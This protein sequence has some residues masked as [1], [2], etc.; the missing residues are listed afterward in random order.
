MVSDP[1]QP[2]AQDAARARAGRRRRPGRPDRAVALGRRDRQHHPERLPAVRRAVGVRPQGRRP[3]RGRG[4]GRAELPARRPGRRRQRRPARRVRARRPGQHLDPGRSSSAIELEGVVDPR[5][6]SKLIKQLEADGLAFEG[7]EASASSCSSAATPPTTP[8]RSGSSTTPASS[9]SATAASC[10]PRRPSRSRSTARSSTPPPTATARSTPSTRPCA[11][12]SA[13]STRASTTSTSSTTRCAS[14]TAAR[15]PRPGPGSIID[16]TDGARTWSTMGS[17]TNIIAASAAALADSLEYAIWKAG[18]ELR[19]RDERHF[20]TDGAGADATGRRRPAARPRPHGGDRDDRRPCADPT[21]HLARWTVTSGSN[22][23]AAAPSSSRSGDHEWRASAEGNGAIDALFRAVDKALA[24]V[25]TGHPRLLAYDIHALGEG[26]DTIGAVT[27]RIAPP[28]VGGERGQ[29]RVHRR[30]ARAEHHRGLDRG[31]HRGA[32]RDARRGALARRDGGRGGNR[33]AGPKPAPVPRTRPASG[34]PSSTRTPARSTRPPG[35]SGRPSASTAACPARAGRTGDRH[36]GRGSG[37]GRK[38]RLA[39]AMSA[40]PMSSPTPASR[41]PSPR[42]PSS[43][44]SATSSAT[45]LGSFREVFEAVAGGDGRGRRR[46]HRERHQRHGPRELRPA[47]RA[48][49]R[50]SAARSSCRSGSASP[51]CP[52]SGS[53]TSSGST[54]TSRRSARPRRSCAR[55]RGSS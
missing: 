39:S 14:S 17:D 50:R 5:E 38:V 12:R 32:Q 34:G 21:L 44:R 11:R 30:G 55:G 42:T 27:V 46:P 4:Q 13:R 49:P 19:R 43:P 31:L 47:A 9:S 8:R 53:R 52:A 40:P 1:G 20:T 37:T 26:T 41:A 7:A 48:R 28:D 45:P 29:R 33:D 2:R 35:S 22:A 36:R 54:R 51:R 16:S 18:A 3:R 23:R 25:L 10:S 24:G 15:R 6:L